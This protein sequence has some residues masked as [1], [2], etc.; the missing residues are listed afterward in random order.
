MTT[1]NPP[2]LM[3]VP[4]YGDSG[5]NH[6]QTLWGKQFRDSARVVQ[7][8][9]ERAYRDEWIEKL[10][11]FIDMTPGPIILIGHSLGSMA[12]VEWA[13]QKK[14]GLPKIQ[15]A[16]LVAYP[17]PNTKAFRSLHI[18]GFEKP[19]LEKL[20]FRSL[21]IISSNDPFI[22]LETGR[23]FAKALGSQFIDIGKKGHIGSDSNLG[24]WPE[25]KELLNQL[26]S[27]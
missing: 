12:I 10:D 8:D 6:W 27:H 16:M 14:K 18:K 26:I 25:G 5:P 9:W 2:T 23:R 11:Q 3:I 13:H 19:T 24:D 7:E 4:G 1:Q 15:G 22:T 20:P 21:F 17:D